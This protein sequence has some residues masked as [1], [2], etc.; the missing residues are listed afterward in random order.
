MYVTKL[1]CFLFV[2]RGRKKQNT[3]LVPGMQHRVPPKYIRNIAHRRRVRFDKR[4]PEASDLHGQLGQ[5]RLLMRNLARQALKHL[6]FRFDQ[7]VPSSDSYGD[8]TSQQT[9]DT[10]LKEQKHAIMSQN[11]LGAKRHNTSVVEW[12]VIGILGL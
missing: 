7:L 10:K 2:R 3:Y 1:D 4:Y 5:Q 6:F 8:Q 9:Q 12:N 11:C